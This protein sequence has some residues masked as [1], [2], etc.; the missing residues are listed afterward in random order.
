MISLFKYRDTC[1][2]FHNLTGKLMSHNSPFIYAGFPSMINMHI[3]TADGSAGGFDDQ[4]ARFED[5]GIGYINTFYFP[6]IL[7]GNRFHSG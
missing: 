7:E 2:G 3:G 6:D 4:V 1:A 5:L